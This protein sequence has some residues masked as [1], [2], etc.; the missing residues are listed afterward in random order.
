MNVHG[1]LKVLLNFIQF[2]VN[3]SVVVAEEVKEDEHVLY[4]Y[5]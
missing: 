4:S 3:L 1:A 2:H 5:Y